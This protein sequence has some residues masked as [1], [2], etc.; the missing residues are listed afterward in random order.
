M[1][2][3]PET[4]AVLRQV[5]QGIVADELK[6]TVTVLRR[7]RAVENAYGTSAEQWAAGGT[8]QGWLV[9]TSATD[10]TS[11]HRVAASTEEFELRLPIDAV[12]EAGD[13]VE[14]GGDV[15]TV[16]N[17]NNEETLPIF[18]EATLRRVQ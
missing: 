4:L 13:R 6:T 7:S 9:S 12:V 5:A 1:S 18:M 10:L 16:Q 17:T 2:I 14:I 11:S 15:F 8:Y 3:T